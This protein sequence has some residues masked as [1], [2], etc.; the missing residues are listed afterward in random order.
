VKDRLGA[1]V[2]DGD[3]APGDRAAAERAA[4][5]MLGIGNEANA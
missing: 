5:A 1:M 4:R 2:L 3:I